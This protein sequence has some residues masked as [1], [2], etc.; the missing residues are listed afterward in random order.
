MTALTTAKRNRMRDSSFALPK[1]RK[2][3]INDVSH[4]RNALA[5]VSAFGTREEKKKVQRAVYRKYPQL[6]D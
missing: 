3:P 6:R 4:A 5:R 1:E 2:Y